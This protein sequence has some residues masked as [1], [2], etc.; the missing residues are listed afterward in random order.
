MNYSS[1]IWPA[2][3]R[4]KAKLDLLNCMRKIPSP[5]L[6]KREFVSL[7]MSEKVREIPTPLPLKHLSLPHCFDA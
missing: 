7:E 3:V 4:V 5:F 1:S 2:A 6:T